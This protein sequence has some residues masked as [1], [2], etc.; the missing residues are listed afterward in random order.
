MRRIRTPSMAAL[1]A[2]EA[3]ARHESFTLAARELSVT[4]SAISRQISLLEESLG[5]SL[6][7]RVKQ[8]VT[9][10]RPGLLYSE[11]VRASL[12]A[13]EQDTLAIAAHG[14]GRGNLE[15]AV[16]PT[17]A[18]EWLIPRLPT[19]YARY[20]DVRINM[21]VRTAPFSFENEHFDA[22]IHHGKPI[23]PHATLELLFGERMVA[24][25]RADLI[26]K[27]LER[28]EDLLQYTLLYST[29]RPESWRQ[30]FELAGVAQMPES[31]GSAGFEL[32]S[33]VVRAAEAG[34]GV[35]LVP[36]FFVPE[37]AW[38]NGVIRAHPLSMLAE[39]SYHLVYPL[40]TRDNLPLQCFR[41]WIHQEARGFAAELRL[42]P[43]DRVDD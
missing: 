17:F 23:W 27:P 32:Q 18:L 13:L 37:A 31:I 39:D 16:L 35:G 19:F 26:G 29:T 34:L 5:V 12:R 4:E 3:A 40:E 11:K 9:L 15:L 6:F 22:A 25:A 24:I 1:T 2:F 20:P 41:E 42:P 10:T 36:E 43:S 8:R 14:S 38:Q 33:M 30:W 28:A 21:G 7:V